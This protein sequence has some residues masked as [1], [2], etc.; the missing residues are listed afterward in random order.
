MCNERTNQALRCLTFFCEMLVQVELVQ[1]GR[2]GLSHGWGEGS[3][4]EL[5]HGAL[6]LGGNEGQ[7]LMG[8]SECF[9]EPLR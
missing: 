5:G 6:E 9:I 8:D 2:G 3:W 4:T 7:G 1:C